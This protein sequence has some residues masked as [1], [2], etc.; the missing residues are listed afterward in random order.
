MSLANTGTA[1][2]AAVVAV[3]TEAMAEG[4]LPVASG[5]GN[6]DASPAGGRINDDGTAAAAEFAVRNEKGEASTD[7]G[8]T[9][10]EVED[11]PVPEQP[12]TLFMLGRA[13]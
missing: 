10:S 11:S 7:G 9:T 1:T 12:V 8:E 2:E 13:P 6:A 3:M 4:Q 5:R